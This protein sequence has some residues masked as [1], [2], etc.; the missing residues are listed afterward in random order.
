MLFVFNVQCY[1][2]LSKTLNIFYRSAKLNASVSSNAKNTTLTPENTVLTSWEVWVLV[3]RFVLSEVFSLFHDSGVWS[4]VRYV[5]GA[6]SPEG[7]LINS[8]LFKI[9]DFTTHSVIA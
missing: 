6:V 5:D 8:I 9:V 3:M 2:V 1:N 7:H 4:K